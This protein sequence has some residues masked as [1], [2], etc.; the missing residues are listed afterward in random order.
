MPFVVIRIPSPSPHYLSEVALT[1]RYYVQGRKIIIFH[2][3]RCRGLIYARVFSGPHKITIFLATLNLA[4][5]YYRF[6]TKIPNF[7]ERTKT[8]ISNPTTDNC[9]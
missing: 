5:P 8:R 1:L 4:T 3:N 2:F 7:V 6:L 9:L